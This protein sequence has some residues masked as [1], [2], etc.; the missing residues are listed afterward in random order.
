[1]I[2]IAVTSVHESAFDCGYPHNLLG[3]RETMICNL[4]ELPRSLVLPDRFHS[5]YFLL[6]YCKNEYWETGVGSENK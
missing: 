4:I 6:T 5:A 1:M 3:C 2:F